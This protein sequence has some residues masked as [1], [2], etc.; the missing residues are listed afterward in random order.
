MEGPFL[1]VVFERSRGG[2]PLKD[3]ANQLFGVL[4]I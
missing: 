3:E 1:S 2:H 4:Q